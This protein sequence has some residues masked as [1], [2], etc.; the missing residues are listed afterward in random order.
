[1]YEIK[2]SLI[3][4][5]KYFLSLYIKLLDKLQEQNPKDKT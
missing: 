3:S 2:G 4:R 5:Q 1:M